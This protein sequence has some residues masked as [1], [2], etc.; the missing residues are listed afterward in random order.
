MPLEKTLLKDEREGLPRQ[1]EDEK[2]FKFSKLANMA[3]WIATLG[4]TAMQIGEASGTPFLYDISEQLG[5]FSISVRDYILGSEQNALQHKI[6]SL[7]CKAFGLFNIFGAQAQLITDKVKGKK[8]S[9]KYFFGLY[10]HPI[11]NGFRFLSAGIT[12]ANPTLENLA[13]TGAIFYTTHKAGKNE[14][15]ELESQ[16]G[17]GIRDDTLFY[18]GYQ[19]IKSDLKEIGNSLNNYLKKL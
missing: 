16:Y 15:E 4:L 3:P 11:Y 19:M 1:A 17:K 2:K 5:N 12:L 10:R 13:L 8:L 6:F 7:S 14:I 18:G 9:D